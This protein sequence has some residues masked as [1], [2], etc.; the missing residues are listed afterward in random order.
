MKGYECASSV[1]NECRLSRL[2][3]LGVNLGRGRGSP[4]IGGRGRG[5]GGGGLSG[6]LGKIGKKPKM[7]TLVSKSLNTRQSDN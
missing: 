1:L 5:G 4:V 3:A 2:S 6:L 7:S